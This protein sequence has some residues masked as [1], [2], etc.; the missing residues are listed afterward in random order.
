MSN[1]YVRSTTGSSGNNGTTWA[2]A[3]DTLANGVALGTNA[4]TVW[5]SQVDSEAISAAGITIT[6]PTTPGLRV[7][8]GNDGAEPPTALAA[9]GV[10]SCTFNANFAI[11]GFGYFYGQTF[12]SAG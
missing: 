10:V 3:K 9:T 11:S 7:L 12:K 2:L 8:C 5:Q 4:D 1:F 6:C